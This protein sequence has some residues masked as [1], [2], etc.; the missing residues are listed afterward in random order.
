MSY[1]LR[2]T[3]HFCKSIFVPANRWFRLIFMTLLV[4]C[5]LTA[6]RQRNYKLLVDVK[7]EED[8]DKAI[9]YTN[10]ITGTAVFTDGSGY[11]HK[12]GAAAVLMQNGFLS[13]TLKYHLGADSAHT[14]Y[15][16]E[17]IAVVLGIHPLCST[18]R[19]YDSVT[20]GLDNQAVLMALH[21]QKSRP[22][23]H[24]L[25]RIHDILEDFQVIQAR[26]RGITVKGYRKGTGRTQLADG[27]RDGKSGS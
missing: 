14:V 25:D 5:I 11:E 20:I 12:I 7:I 16:A 19:Y 23:H 21:T 17:A 2:F 8:R 10:Q 18:D 6:R 3:D 1:L 24:I 9:K 27:T 13:R 22:G 26:K 4:H 15:E